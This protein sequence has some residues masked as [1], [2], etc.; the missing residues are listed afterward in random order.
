MD[1]GSKEAARARFGISPDKKVVFVVGGSMGARSIKRGAVEALPALFKD[2]RIAVI[3]STGLFANAEYHAYADTIER[4]QRM[5]LA[6]E[7]PGRYV[8]KRFIDDV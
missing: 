8:C 1:A 5:G 3:H 6:P 2:E 7:I 4:L